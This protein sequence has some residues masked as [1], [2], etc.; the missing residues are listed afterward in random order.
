MNNVATTLHNINHHSNTSG[1]SASWSLL[2]SQEVFRH[3]LDLIALEDKRDF[4]L[5]L[6]RVPFLVESESNPA[7]FLQREDFHIAKAVKRVCMYW[8]YRCE[9][10][11][12]ERAFCPMTLTGDGAFSPEDVAGYCAGTL[13]PIQGGPVPVLYM[14]KMP[15]YSLN[16][17]VRRKIHFYVMQCLSE[18]DA[19]I[20]PGFAYVAFCRDMLFVDGTSRLIA[21]VTK[22]GL[23]VQLASGH[24]FCVPDHQSSSFADFL[25]KCFAALSTIFKIMLNTNTLIHAH[26]N[27]IQRLQTMISLGIP[28]NKVPTPLGGTFTREDFLTWVKQRQELERQR[29]LDFWFDSSLLELFQHGDSVQNIFDQTQ[30]QPPQAMVIAQ[31]QFE[32]SLCT[33][34]PQFMTGNLE[35]I[36]NSTFNAARH[37]HQTE[38]N[39]FDV[40][41]N[42]MI[43]NFPS[44][45]NESERACA[46]L[47]LLVK[48][49]K[50]LPRATC[51]GGQGDA[52]SRLGIQDL[53]TAIEETDE[54]RR[55]A[56]DAI[57]NTVALVPVGERSAYVE[58]CCRCPSLTETESDVM[59]FLRL[60][61]YDVHSGVGRLVRYW[62]L[63]Q[64][65]FGE[66]AF[67]P[68]SQDGHG[69]LTREDV[70]L[71][72]SG[73]VVLLPKD[74]EGRSVIME[75]R[76][77]IL[78]DNAAAQH[79]KLRCLFYVLSLLSDNSNCQGDGFVWLSVVIAPRATNI[80]KEFARKSLEVLDCFPIRLNA[81]HLFVCPPK[82]W[83]KSVVDDVV[84]YT[85]SLF[86][87]KYGKRT[88]VHSGAEAGMAEKLLP[89]GLIDVSLPASLG[90]SW[91]Y[92]SWLTFLRQQC[93]NELAR[94]ESGGIHADAVN[95][96]R[97]QPLTKA[98]RKPHRRKLNTIYSRQKRERQNA[99]VDR[100]KEQCNELKSS[101]QALTADNA[102]LER[103]LEHAIDALTEDG[104]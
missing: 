93:Q 101:N 77:R 16:P 52:Y 83:K 57:E 34:F 31:N 32:L 27:P 78:D 72:K 53:H 11:G 38:E 94:N 80:W 46:K 64:D 7:K 89:F 87:S 86:D 54:I 4:L 91:A 41:E 55:T 51:P 47:M 68:M 20:R 60:N 104:L 40:E 49:A 1:N 59:R 102:R 44:P 33:P 56:C 30:Q 13:F 35:H 58:A 76:N 97:A 43:S 88:I 12:N 39:F 21:K 92:E 73:V 23:P 19:S 62:R 79:A 18:D 24:I 29:Y 45:G 71:L 65:I 17:E 74:S 98:E 82:T 8:K 42:T 100:L 63:R 2:L 9:I 14:D 66:R 75:D 5:A 85:V 28:A 61:N 15:N 10:F 3:S 25:A 50:P 81:A 103:L 99:R 37:L 36:P 96:P 22:E 84:S 69:T 48:Q 67:L 6:E 26:A 70:V 90:G 95:T